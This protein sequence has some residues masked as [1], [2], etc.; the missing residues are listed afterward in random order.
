MKLSDQ[1]EAADCSKV[2]YRAPVHT[3]SET[4]CTPDRSKQTGDEVCFLLL[5]RGV[6]FGI[7][8]PLSLITTLTFITWL[9]LSVALVVLNIY[10]KISF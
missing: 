6:P 9:L 4:A 8:A 5:P 2:W 10:F 3:V 7:C 1:V